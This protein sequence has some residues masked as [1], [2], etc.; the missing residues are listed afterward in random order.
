M[1]KHIPLND[2]WRFRLGFD[3]SWLEETPTEGF[4]EVE[5][6][7]CSVE[8]KND[9]F[10]PNDMRSLSTYI[11]TL[12]VPASYDG[13]KLS[14]AFEGADSYAEVYCNGMFV[15]AHKGSTPFT[16]DITAPVKFDY[17]NILL[18]KTDARVKKDVP[19]TSKTLLQ[20][21]GIH[22]KVELVIQEGP[23]IDDVAVIAGTGPDVTADV[24]LGEY[25]PD[26]TVEG[27]VTDAD[28][29]EVG[30]LPVK[31]VLGDRVHLVGSCSAYQLW[32]PDS[33]ALYT[34]T[35]TLR[36]GD[37]I[38]DAVNVRFG[39]RTA[40]FFR[41][42]FRLN[43]KKVKLIGLNRIDSYP[44]IGRAEP[45]SLAASDARLLKRLGVNAVRTVGLPA[46]AFIETC[47]EIG[48]MVIEDFGGDGSIGDARWKSTL[49]DNISETV[50][51]DRNSPSV[52]A[53]GVRV[54]NSPDCDELYFKTTQKAHELDP[55]RAAVGSRS[56]MGSRLY[57]DVFGFNETRRRGLSRPKKTAGLTIPYIVTEHAAV[58]CNNFDP[59]AVRLEQAYAH[60]DAVD[61]MLG[62]NAIDGCFGSSFNDY[63]TL[64]H[65]GSGDSVCHTGVTDGYRNCKPAAYAYMSQSDA[66]PVLYPVEPLSNDLFDGKLTVFTNCDYVRLFR[67]ESV[68]G[69]FYPDRKRYRH[70]PHPPVVIDDFIGGLL[71]AEGL[72]DKKAKVVKALLHRVRRK[73]FLSI[74]RLGRFVARLVGVGMDGLKKLADKYVYALVSYRLEGVKNGETVV[75]RSVGYAPQSGNAH[76]MAI[77][78][79]MPEIRDGY[80]MIAVSVTAVDGFGT[81]LTHDN[82]PVRV[83]ASGSVAVVGNDPR[84]FNG[85]M[86]GFYVKSVAPGPGK[87]IVWSRWGKSEYDLEVRYE[88][89]EKL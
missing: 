7:H 83:A 77:E 63:Y 24:T 43:G 49:I 36:S 47:D 54:N 9:Y 78:C 52:I 12:V 55:T 80:E 37:Q 40:A 45:D 34:L 31:S 4:R 29:V 81:V 68:V 61:K 71:A 17:P 64:R 6:P 87:I 35:V 60:L 58:P 41:S 50:L 69:E 65:R 86:T 89:V 2:R 19:E 57:E 5:L 42:G 13:C 1:K 51:R 84:N 56:F 75:S 10:E 62:S 85:G 28:G 30:A 22:R 67:G 21:G 32:T 18:V 14:L 15:T 59:V 48:L 16:A 66:E 8:L 72:D 39:F 38:L 73:G 26:T 44:G 23:A 53:W 25:Y 3:K 33:P 79:G 20:Y 46:K 27:I 88:S 76:H 11:R 82:S 70:L 74:G